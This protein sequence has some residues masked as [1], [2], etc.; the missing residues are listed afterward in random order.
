MS[1]LFKFNV[2]PSGIPYSNLA[3]GSLSD[4]VSLPFSRTDDL[5]A[6]GT[7]AQSNQENSDELT[8][9]LNSDPQNTNFIKYY[10]P[11]DLDQNHDSLP[12]NVFKI[13]VFQIAGGQLTRSAREGFDNTT[14]ALGNSVAGVFGLTAFNNTPSVSESASEFSNSLVNNVS[15]ETQIELVPDAVMY[16]YM[17]DNIKVNY[18]FEYNEANLS[19]TERV[20]DIIRNL[21]NPTSDAMKQNIL[22]L[23]EQ[24]GINILNNAINTALPDLGIDLPSLISARTKRIPYYNYE[25][26]FQR[27]QRRTFNFE[28]QLYPRNNEEIQSMLGIVKTLKFYS[29]PEREKDTRWLNMP[30]VFDIGYYYFDSD[31]SLKENLALNRMKLCALTN[32]TV[33]Y[34]DAGGEFVVLKSQEQFDNITYKSPVGIKL[35][36]TFTELDLLTRNDMADPKVGYNENNLSGKYY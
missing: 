7:P 36:T 14:R 10:F 20:I 13:G 6:S 27:V 29:H 25:Y 33:D 16:L 19:G 34:C 11:A 15:V 17:P 21:N 1:E 18:G 8:R 24:Y 28:W 31:G 26:L 12:K 2:N 22:S 23:V 35:S 4:S 32:L 5:L 3:S 9:R 30:G